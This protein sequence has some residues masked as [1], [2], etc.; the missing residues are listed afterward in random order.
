MPQTNDN[1][2]FVAG[3]FLLATGFTVPVRAADNGC[4]PVFDAMTKV[5]ATPTRLYVTG[6]AAV[7]KNKPQNSEM[8]YAGG[9]IYLKLGEKWTRSTMTAAAM[10]KQEEENR[11]TAKYSCR[12]LREETVNG[13]TAAV[14]ANHSETEDIKSDA[15]VW[16]S[17][18]RG[19]PLRTEGDYD[20]GD[21]AKTHA[22]I[23][24]DYSN[25]RPPAGVQ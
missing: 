2:R 10:L 9:A 3:V 23:R 16:I 19:L 4:Q 11:R 12:Y 7:G 14:Y 22:S 24:Y 18:S 17:K 8:I 20:T 25:V 1:V 6:G 5:L 13:E 15:T 21:P